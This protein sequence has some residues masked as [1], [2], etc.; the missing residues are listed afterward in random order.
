MASLNSGGAT[1]NFQDL[2]RSSTQTD[3]LGRVIPNGT[4]LDP[5]TTRQ[6]SPGVF[7]RDPF[8]TCLNAPA[9]FVYTIAGCG[10]NL[11]PMSRL[12]PNAIALLN[13]YPS[14]T[15]NSLTSN[16]ATSPKLFEHRNS[17][18]ARMDINSTKRTSC[19]YRF[20]LV[21]DPQIIPSIFGGVADGGGFQ[22]G[23]RL[24]TPS[25]V[26]WLYPYVFSDMMNVDPR[27]IE[28]SAH[29]ARFSVRQ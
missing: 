14:P 4:V 5:A 8:G 13:L 24:R 23:T 7:V 27:R 28:L 3:A 15:N 25:R 9:G 19:F 22:Q 1:A 11:I 12:D 2:I 10:L 26:P 16:F 21:D 6:I 17:F 18:D 29:H 20:S